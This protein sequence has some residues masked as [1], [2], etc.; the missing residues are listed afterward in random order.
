MVPS[1][2]EEETMGALEKPCRCPHCQ[3]EIC[4][5]EGLDG[6]EVAPFPGCFSFCAYCGGLSTFDASMNLVRLNADDEARAHQSGHGPLLEKVRE[7]HRE[8]DGAGLDFDEFLALRSAE[9]RPDDAA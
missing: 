3:E 4:G 7:I 9:W 2:D 8:I 5:A 6:T 1:R